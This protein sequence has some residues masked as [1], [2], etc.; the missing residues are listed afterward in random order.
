MMTIPRFNRRRLIAL[1]GWAG[2]TAVP[3]AG[4]TANGSTSTMRAAA[5]ALLDMAFNQKKVAE[6]FDLYVGPTYKQHN[7][8][9]PDGRDAAIRLLSEGVAKRDV[10]YEVKRSAAEADLVFVHS[11]VK[12]G[13]DPRGNAVVDIFRFE[14]GKIVEHWDVVQAVPEK[15]AN[16]NTMF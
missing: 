11:N 13:G 1:L 14:K 10:R 6:A 16:D 12:V 4:R 15:S 7:P 2:L 3:L 9:V 5:V 8:N